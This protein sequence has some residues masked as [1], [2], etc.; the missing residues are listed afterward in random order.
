M[1]LLITAGVTVTIHF[2]GGKVISVQMLPI[3][4]KESPCGCDES[5]TPDDC[6]K[7]EMKS[8]QVND[9]QI[10]VQVDQPISPLSDVNLWAETSFDEL[11]S[12]N[13]IRTV[14]PASSPPDS[15]PSYILH[16]TLLI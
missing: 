14:L 12:S 13:S 3:I 4:P 16:R 1:Y 6:C 10:A 9:E 2:C 15:T 5:T 8:F 7:T 11:F